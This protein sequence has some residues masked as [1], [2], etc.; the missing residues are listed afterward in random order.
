MGQPSELARKFQIQLWELFRKYVKIP[1]IATGVLLAR[2]KTV[3]KRIKLKLI[4]YP[5]GKSRRLKKFNMEIEIKPTK[6]KKLKT[7]INT[8]V[9]YKSENF[10]LK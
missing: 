5:K 2:S 1:K 6:S 7:A 9:S 4:Y 8:V 3:K 10:S